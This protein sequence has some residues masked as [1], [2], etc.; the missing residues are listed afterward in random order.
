[1]VPKRRVLDEQ[2]DAFVDR[3]EN[4]S[5]KARAARPKPLIGHRPSHRHRAR[6]RIFGQPSPSF[7]PKALTRQVGS[8]VST[9]RLILRAAAASQQ[10]REPGA[11]HGHDE[12]TVTINELLATSADRGSAQRRA[13]RQASAPRPWETPPF[14]M[15]R[16]RSGIKQEWTSSSDV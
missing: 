10:R 9:C 1:V 16:T 7:S 5:R 8:A 15:A 14:E 6:D 11:V 13:D 4:S 3:Q 2:L 12:I